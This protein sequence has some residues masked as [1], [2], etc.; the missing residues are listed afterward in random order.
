MHLDASR[1]EELSGLESKLRVTSWRHS[2]IG[3]R[4]QCQAHSVH[5]TLPFV[6]VRP[7]HEAS[8]IAA[9]VTAKTLDEK[10]KIS[11]L[12]ASVLPLLFLLFTSPAFPTVSPRD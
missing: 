10:E 6:R 5:G 9:T 12:V 11:S 7:E 1:I 3:L 4:S 2:A 8:R